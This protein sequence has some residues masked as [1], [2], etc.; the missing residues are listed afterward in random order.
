MQ[1]PEHLKP[2][3]EELE[4]RQDNKRLADLWRILEANARSVDIWTADGQISVTL[5][6]EDPQR[7]QRAVDAIRK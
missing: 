6:P 2:V 5:S 7:L 4:R 3:V 1:L